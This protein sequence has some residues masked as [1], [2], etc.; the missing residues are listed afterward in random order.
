VIGGRYGEREASLEGADAVQLPASGD[1]VCPGG[2]LR[3]KTL[4]SA[5]RQVVEG[6]KDE[7][8]ADIVA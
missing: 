1:L 5:E 7:S 4:T 6:G 3:A 8:L 2:H